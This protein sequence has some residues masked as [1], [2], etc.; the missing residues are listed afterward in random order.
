MGR[1]LFGTDG[2]RGLPGRFPLDDATLHATGLAI[3]HY[4]A[5][6]TSG[7]RPRVLLGMDT[8]ESGPHLAAHLAKGL[9][10]A[11]AEP[12]SAGVIPTPGVAA[13]VRKK[14]FVAGVVISASHNPFTDN[15]VKLFSHEGMK[16]PDQV[17][18]QLEAEILR[19]RETAP[20]GDGEPAL[21][22]QPGLEDEYLAELR[23]RA[24]GGAKLDGLPIV[25]DCANGAASRL[26][27]KLFS[28][29]GAHVTAIHNAPD[30]RNINAGCGSLHP[31]SMCRAVRESGARLGVAFDG[32]ADRAL[33]STASGRLVDGDGVLYLSARMLK[34]AGRLRGG[35]VVGTA[36]TNLGL[37]RALAREEIGL[38][39]VPVGDRYVLEEMLRRGA[40]LGGEP[41]GHIIFLDEGPAGDGLATALKVA[42]AVCRDGA[43]EQLVSG[44]ELYP[45][46][47]LNVPVREK[48]PLN[49]LPEVAQL[50]DK[51]REALGEAN[52]IVLRYSGTERVARVMVEAREKSEVERWAAAL[53]DAIR[54]HV[55]AEQQ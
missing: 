44:L 31:E 39:R 37:E 19:L 48:P 18:E 22:P 33:F 21:S 28:S 36:M 47:I 45:Q 4:V 9:A 3:G 35:A 16:F 12:V 17:E 27:P 40:N 14:D 32:D 15:G 52:R 10:E 20:A 41:S 42:A 11:G 30:G 34:A 6:L 7:A 1:E 5:G 8:R 25:L 23:T 13:L 29:L 50:A 24:D 2:I 53:A 51:A 49:S 55:G 54:R 43:L 38:V 26:G 46:I